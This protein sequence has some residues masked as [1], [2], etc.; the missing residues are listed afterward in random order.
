MEN[1]WKLECKVIFVERDL[2]YALDGTC[3]W[4]LLQLNLTE[5][6]IYGYVLYESTQNIHSFHQNCKNRTCFY[7]V[8]GHSGRLWKDAGDQFFVFTSVG[9]SWGHLS[10]PTFPTHRMSHSPIEQS[11]GPC[12]FSWL[13]QQEGMLPSSPRRSLWW[14]AMTHPGLGPRLSPVFGALGEWGHLTS[15]AW[16]PWEPH[17]LPHTLSPS[18][19]GC[20][21]VL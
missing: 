12:S 4:E 17:L 16:V 9:G 2:F 6:I 3:W 14:G 1:G 20:F 8:W 5:K 11:S 10:H 13:S 7:T 15:W 21:I 19:Q 18:H